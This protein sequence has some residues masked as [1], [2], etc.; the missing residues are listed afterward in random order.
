[1]CVLCG[2]SWWAEVLWH[3]QEALAS[4]TAR[5]FSL[6]GAFVDLRADANVGVGSPSAATLR[7][8][9][10][11]ETYGRAAAARGTREVLAGL[12]V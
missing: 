10:C 7:Q 5:A 3:L 8:E 12:G 11:R 9:G 4:G 1:M 2:S 6:S